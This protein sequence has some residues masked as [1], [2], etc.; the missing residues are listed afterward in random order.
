M[1]LLMNLTVLAM[2]RS[3]ADSQAKRYINP[4]GE[5]LVIVVDTVLL[6]CLIYKN[7]PAQDELSTSQ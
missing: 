5:I 2:Y 1:F 6:F 3:M 7:T 4:I